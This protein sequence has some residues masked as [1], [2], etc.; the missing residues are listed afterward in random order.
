MFFVYLY[1]G[2]GIW[3]VRYRNKL[4]WFLKLFFKNFVKD[5]KK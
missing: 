3:L 5:E 1:V 2:L 4:G